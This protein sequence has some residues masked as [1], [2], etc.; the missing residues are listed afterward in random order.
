MLPTRDLFQNKR[1]TQVES[2]G[3]GKK[4]KFQANGHKKKAGEAIFIPDK[5]DLKIKAIK[6]DKEGHYIILKGVI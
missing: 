1:P 6:R 3:T 4:K 2:A 5:I